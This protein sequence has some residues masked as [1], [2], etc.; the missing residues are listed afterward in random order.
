MSGGYSHL[1][2]E[3]GYSTY[4]AADVNMA[5]VAGGTLGKNAEIAENIQT[6]Q[7]R[8]A[9]LER[10]LAK[11]GTKADDTEFRGGLKEERKRAH[12]LAKAIIRSISENSNADKQIMAKLRRQF[13]SEFQKFQQLSTQIENKEKEI[14]TAM[15]SV[16]EGSDDDL[17]KPGSS[18]VQPGDHS[19]R[20]QQE[21][22]IDIQFLEYNEAEIK[23]RHENVLQI[24]RDA[25]EVFEMYKDMQTL[26]GEQQES[27]D[28]IDN[29]IS[30]TKAKTEEAAKELLEAEQYQQKARKKQCC[31]LF[32]VLAVLAAIILTVWASS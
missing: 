25:V 2:Q 26:V 16:A 19:Q 29:N 5:D 13:D 32:I 28:V 3:Q 15:G 22:N 31:L 24:E 12:K 4:Q 21:G 30:E 9:K 18:V 27:I 11:M 23:R 17:R 6:L 20:Q 14:I 1:P 7:K 10:M 8:N